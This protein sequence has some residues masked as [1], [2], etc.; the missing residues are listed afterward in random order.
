[1]GSAWFSSFRRREE[2]HLVTETHAVNKTLSARTFRFITIFYISMRLL[3]LRLLFVSVR[4]AGPFTN[5]IC[6]NW[7]LFSLYK[8]LNC[9]GG[10]LGHRNWDA[11]M[12]RNSFFLERESTVLPATIW[13]ITVYL[14][15]RT[16]A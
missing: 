12:A 9:V 14:G 11:S 1:M 16:G 15:G 3:L 8:F 5:K 4:A 2:E 7:R 13:Y 6:L 10:P